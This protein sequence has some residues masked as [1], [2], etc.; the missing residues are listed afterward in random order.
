[1]ESIYENLKIDLAHPENNSV[2]VLIIS[3][4]GSSCRQANVSQCAKLYTL[5]M[6]TVCYKCP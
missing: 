1:M 5:Y 2:L 4:V 3:L 6:L